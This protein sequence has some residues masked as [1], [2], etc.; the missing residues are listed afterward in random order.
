MTKHR[1]HSA[2]FKRPVAQEFIAGETLHGLSKRHDVSRQLI[3]IWVGKDE[4]GALDEDAQA[5]DM[6]QEYE[7]KIAA[8]GR[9]ALDWPFEVPLAVD[10]SLLTFPGL[11]G[12]PFKSQFRWREQGVATAGGAFLLVKLWV[13]DGRRSELA[14]LCESALRRRS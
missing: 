10:A 6:L 3:R 11:G 4:A 1:R 12:W 8:L 7:A 13:R 9:A 14:D 5:A 2:A